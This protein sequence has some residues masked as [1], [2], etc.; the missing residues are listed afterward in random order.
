MKY[1]MVY[2]DGQG[3]SGKAEDIINELMKQ[4][5]FE[6]YESIDDFLTKATQNIWR[7]FQVGIDVGQGTLEERCEKFL[8][9]AIENGLLQV[10]K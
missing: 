8:D 9:A 6:T 2:I 5:Y 3:I 4:G 1:Y 10:T 7:L